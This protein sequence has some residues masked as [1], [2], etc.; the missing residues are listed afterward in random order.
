MSAG[1]FFSLP[2][3]L[4]EWNQSLI[5]VRFKKFFHLFA[6]TSPES[7]APFPHH[8]STASLTPLT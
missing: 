2:L 6:L 4:I 5:L 1:S 8:A 7:W 3:W